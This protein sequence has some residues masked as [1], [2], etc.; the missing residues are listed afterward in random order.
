MEIFEPE[1]DYRFATPIKY[2][3]EEWQNNIS[4]NDLRESSEKGTLLLKNSA[5]P[6]I[7]M[8]HYDMETAM[9]H[10]H[11]LCS[12]I[13]NELVGF[14]WWTLCEKLSLPP[15]Q[16]LYP[17]SELTINLL[18]KGLLELKNE[19]PIGLVSSEGKAHSLGSI[20]SEEITYNPF[21][22]SEI[23]KKLRTSYR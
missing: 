5:L 15:N 23:Y 17:L 1:Y 20:L 6:L 18:F 7:L 13:L 21:R 22:S 8:H 19:L 16:A 4:T 11:H 9:V 10:S 12:V 3:Y 2:T 14:H